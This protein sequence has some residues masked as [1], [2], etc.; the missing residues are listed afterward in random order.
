M[1]LPIAG[2]NDK[3]RSQQIQFY[4]SR[5]FKRLTRDISTRLNSNKEG[6]NQR[7]FENGQSSRL[8]GSPS[9]L[10]RNNFLVSTKD[11]LS[12]QNFEFGI[13]Q[14][15]PQKRLQSAH[16]AQHL[17]RAKRSSQHFLQPHK[18]GLN[19]KNLLSLES[20]DCEA[21]LLTQKPSNGDIGKFRG[22]MPQTQKY[23]NNS[24]SFKFIGMFNNPS[25]KNFEQTSP[26]KS[27]GTKEE[28]V[29]VLTVD[30]SLHEKLL[31]QP[32]PPP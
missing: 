27:I 3:M 4:Y 19:I 20:R 18:E 1:S 23:P 30:P 26:K 24:H 8:Q 11:L 5:G 22:S 28:H 9:K 2:A 6:V 25:A 21:F 14:H 13:T 17:A 12:S 7:Q 10:N 31:F 15:V 32:S 29:K 16:P